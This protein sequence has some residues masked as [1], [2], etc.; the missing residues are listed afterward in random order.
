MNNGVEIK[1]KTKLLDYED[2]FKWWG[3]YCGYKENYK[4]SVQS[5][6]SLSRELFDSICENEKILKI[7][8]LRNNNFLGYWF[9]T[10]DLALYPESHYSFEYFYDN[11]NK[12]N[13]NVIMGNRTPLFLIGD[14]CGF[15][16]SKYTDE[17]FKNKILNYIKLLESLY[18][19]VS[20]YM[21]QKVYLVMNY[22]EISLK[23]SNLYFADEIL[24]RN[25][26]NNGKMHLLDEETFAHI[27][28]QET[29]N[30][31]TRAEYLLQIFG[32]FIDSEKNHQSQIIYKFN[33]IFFKNR[34]FISKANIIPEDYKN[35][36]Y[37]LYHN[38]LKG[39]NKSSPQ[40]LEYTRDEFISYLSNPSYD[41]YLLI[42]EDNKIKGLYLLIGKQN[43][44]KANWVSKGW[45]I[46]DAYIKLILTSK[47]M[48]AFAYLILFVAGT[49]DLLKNQGTKGNARIL[50]DW[51]EKING[52]KF[53]K[54]LNIERAPLLPNVIRLSLTKKKGRYFAR[55][56]SIFAKFDATKIDSDVYLAYTSND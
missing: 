46:A 24:N 8:V 41:K 10:D 34:F 20:K 37:D 47:K 52:Y 11:K 13:K 49:R 31:K 25:G 54:D 4:S 42:D 9:V 7:S 28:W 3:F 2:R 51:S 19:E 16:L 33:S 21:N 45:R 27:H 6:P 29:L 23:L 50:A 17:L 35:I 14:N 55:L 48:P 36:I 5:K 32:Q 56:L 38:R 44:D 40:K 43:S 12:K 53:R 18:V 1:I 30:K 26:N 15:I 22:S 39:I